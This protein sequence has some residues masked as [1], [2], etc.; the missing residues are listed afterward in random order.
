MLE[1]GALA[2]QL[3]WLTSGTQTNKQIKTNSQFLYI[4]FNKWHLFRQSDVEIY[5]QNI[6]AIQSFKYLSIALR[7]YR[8]F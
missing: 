1:I 4:Y 6:V 5:R 8:H 3:H 7:V 2:Q